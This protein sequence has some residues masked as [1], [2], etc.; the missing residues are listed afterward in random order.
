MKTFQTNTGKPSRSLERKITP[1][2]GELEAS[3]QLTLIT[4][5]TTKLVRLVRTI[6]KANFNLKE[7]SRISREIGRS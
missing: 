1:M 2:K 5:I 3:V 6:R 7:H 4:K